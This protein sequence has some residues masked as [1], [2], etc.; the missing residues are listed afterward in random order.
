MLEV[1]QFYSFIQS[2]DVLQS[3]WIYTL[4]LSM[5]A[6]KLRSTESE[7]PPWT[8]RILWSI[9]V[10]IGN[11]LKTSSNKRITLFACIQSQKSN[12]QEK[13]IN[14]C[15]VQKLFKNISSNK[16]L[17]EKIIQKLEEK[18]PL[19]AFINHNSSEIILTEYFFTSSLTKPYL[20]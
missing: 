12:E 15:Q 13:K 3:S 7:T 9:M 18:K 6:K 1:I 14:N 16:I 20:E 10:A 8:T 4:C 5:V 19:Y 2:K 17:H 11:Q